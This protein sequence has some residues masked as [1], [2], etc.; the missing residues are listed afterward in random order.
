MTIEDLRAKIAQRGATQP[1]EAMRKAVAN[2]AAK[3]K[4]S[5]MPEPEAWEQYGVP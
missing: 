1:N 3:W 4:A 2:A 5:Q